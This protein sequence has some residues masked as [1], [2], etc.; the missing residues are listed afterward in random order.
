MQLSSSLCLILLFLCCCFAQTHA[1]WASKEQISCCNPG[2]KVCKTAISYLWAKK[3]VQFTLKLSTAISQ[4]AILTQ[5]FPVL[6]SVFPQCFPSVAFI[7]NITSNF[8]HWFSGQERWT[9]TS[10]LNLIN[11][12][13]CCPFEN[14]STLKVADLTPVANCSTRGVK[15]GCCFWLICHRDAIRGLHH[16]CM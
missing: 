7:L 8:P 6:Y 11:T 5:A 15:H 10:C 14:I 16:T 9:K 3:D 2:K 4:S 1:A 13:K 12:H